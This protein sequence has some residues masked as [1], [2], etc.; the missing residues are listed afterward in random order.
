VITPESGGRI[1]RM[2]GNY[3]VKQ[4]MNKNFR[5]G[6]TAPKALPVHAAGS[7]YLRVQ[8]N[9]KK[10]AS[11][12]MYFKFL[13]K[14]TDVEESYSTTEERSRSSSMQIP[15]IEKN[16]SLSA[17]QILG[18]GLA[19]LLGQ[20]HVICQGSGCYATSGQGL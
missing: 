17:T 3:R 4:A 16:N 1:Q 10:R 19:R 15:Q 7:A 18:V 9:Y 20:G 11:G 8:S 6:T 12:N 5:C 13:I 2:K 14:K